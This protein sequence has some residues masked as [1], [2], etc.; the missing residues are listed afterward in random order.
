[1]TLN[2]LTEED[3]QLILDGLDA[4]PSKGAMG[5]LFSGFMDH[6]MEKNISEEEKVERERSRLEQRKKEEIE[7]QEMIENIKI[8]QGKLLTIKRELKQEAA[9]SGANGIVNP[10]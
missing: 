10:N 3:F 5:T 2:I 9:V 1:M 7:K 6:L 8:L 4:L